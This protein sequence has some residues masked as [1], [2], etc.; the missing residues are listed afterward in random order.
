[1]KVSIVQNLLVCILKYPH[2]RLC[3]IKFCFQNPF[4]LFL[5]SRH[6][7]TLSASPD[8]VKLD[9]YLKVKVINYIRRQVHFRTCCYCAEKFECETSL[10]EHMEK[11]NH[12]RLP[13]DASLWNQSQLVC[14]RARVCVCVRVCVCFYVS[15]CPCVCRGCFCVSICLCMLCVRG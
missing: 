10:K 8:G 1:M 12:C 7:F 6:H 5:Q 2:L 4:N 11:E 14:V 3:S 13:S 15:I 9:F